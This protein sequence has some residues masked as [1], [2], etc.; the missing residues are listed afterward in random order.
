[1]NQK[2]K[3]EQSSGVGFTVYPKSVEKLRKAYRIG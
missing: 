3:K 2:T 1:M